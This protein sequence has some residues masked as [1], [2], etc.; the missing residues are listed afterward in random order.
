MAPQPDENNVL[1]ALGGNSAPSYDNQFLQTHTEEEDE[2]Q[3]FKTWIYAPLIAF[4]L[5][6]LLIVLI[7]FRRRRRKVNNNN[8][9]RDALAR[10]LEALGHEQNQN[11]TQ[12]IYIVRTGSGGEP[13]EVIRAGRGRI[14]GLGLRPSRWQWSIPVPGRRQQEEGLNEFGEAPP[15]YDPS[16]RNSIPLNEIPQSSDT[17]SRISEEE[18]RETS[19]RLEDMNTHSSRTG[20]QAGSSPSTERLS[21]PDADETP[22][23]GA[24]PPAYIREP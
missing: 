4:M 22:V 5:V 3:P 9:L 8:M 2:S 12:R 18:P 6:A 17:L 11:G 23:P 10:D 19:I 20:E 24:P 21:S 1:D 7:Q 14:S 15:P 13:E 16:K